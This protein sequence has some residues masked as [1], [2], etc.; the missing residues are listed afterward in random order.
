MQL[1]HASC[2]INC[3]SKHKRRSEHFQERTKGE[4]LKILDLLEENVADDFEA[5]D[6]DFKRR[7]VEKKSKR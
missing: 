7:W 6:L 3:K 5:Q 2:R 1:K 4:I